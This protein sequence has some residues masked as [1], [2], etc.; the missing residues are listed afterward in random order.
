MYSHEI[1]SY[2]RLRDHKLTRNECNEILN[3]NNSPQINWMKYYPGNN[4]YQIKTTDGYYFI[5]FIKE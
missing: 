3:P 1:D 2:L 4:E 5:F